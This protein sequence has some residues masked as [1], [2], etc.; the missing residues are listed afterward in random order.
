MDRSLVRDYMTTDVVVLRPDDGFKEV[1]R[2][3][4]DRGVSGAPVVSETGRVMGVVSEADLLHKEAFM[5][6]AE[7]PRRYFASRSS[8]R[9]A[10]ARSAADTA[11]DL[12]HTPAITVTMDTPITRAARTMA[13]QG[14]KRLP[15]VGDDGALVGIISRADVMGVFL[16]PDEELRREV[17]SEVVERSLWEDPE[18]IRV[19]VRDG[20]VT[21][22]GRLASKSLIPLTVALTQSIDG[23][24]DV[25]DELS[26]ER[27]DTVFDRP[28]LR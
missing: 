28:G 1:V 21:L 10:Q 14:I 19:E 25:I 3:L 12:M 26:Y 8:T 2:A 22:S 4:A 27:D 24:V 20:V 15:V 18:R 5:P 16:A 23:V 6:V 9:A 13:V 17:I 11:A 7:E